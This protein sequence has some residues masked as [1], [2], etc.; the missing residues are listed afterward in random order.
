MS[1]P[2]TYVVDFTATPL[3]RPDDQQT[4]RLTVDG[5]EGETLEEELKAVHQRFGYRDPTTEVMQVEVFGRYD[6]PRTVFIRTT[7][8]RYHL[9]TNEEVLVALPSAH[10]VDHVDNVMFIHLPAYH[11]LKVWVDSSGF[12]AQ[13]AFGV[14]ES[15]STAWRDAIVLAL[16]GYLASLQK[17]ME[18]YVRR[19][20]YTAELLR[21]LERT[22]TTTAGPAPAEETT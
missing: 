9:P 2:D 12:H 6:L 16:Q 19:K 11:S 1:S 10:T 4:F 18:V 17:D 14:F 5:S 21:E 20:D 3:N 7:P 8:A 22:A 15:T 13:H